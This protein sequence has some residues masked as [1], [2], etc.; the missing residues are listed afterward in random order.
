MTNS[1]ECK[2]NEMSEKY[3][4]TS[5]QY[6]ATPNIKFLD[7]LD[8]YCKVNNAE[9]I[10]LPM[11][12]RSIADE[13][14]G[15]HERLQQYKIIDSNYNL[16]SKIRISSYRILPQM[17]DPIT[18]LARF[19]QNDVSTIFASPKVRMKVIPNSNKDLPKVLMT[20]G[21]VTNPYYRDNR[22]GR[23]A[24]KDHTYAALVVETRGKIEYH[25]RQLMSLKNG[26]FFDLGMKYN[27][28]NTPVGSRPEAF[29]LGDW[30][31]GDTNKKVKEETFRMIT[32]YNPKRI[33]LHDFFNGYS[34]NHHENGNIISQIRKSGIT[35]ERELYSVARELGEFKK[36]IDGN[37]EIVIVKSNHDEW[38]NQYI[39]NGGFMK[40]SKNT[41]IGAKLLSEMV[42]GVDP[43]EY[44]LRRYSDSNVKFLS[45]DDDYKVRGW[46]LGS[47]GHLGAN[48]ARG[49]L[50]SIEAA[51][52]K[53]ITG[54]KHSPEVFRNTWVV[55][56]ST[57]LKLEYNRGF[58]SWMNTHA[59]LYE[60][61]LAQLIN[62]ING[63]HKVK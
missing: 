14:I 32:E 35:L 56:T 12:G 40:D 53:S 3:V 57:D 43:L 61:G 54:H 25:Y 38:L 27:G 49:S 30:H 18:G 24:E 17:I 42:Q 4:I 50:R 63:R 39:E 21:A 26:I 6:G 9:L 36:V 37:T 5:A 23:I 48:G 55:G 41:I 52:G 15:L 19:T 47:H 8:K 44:S 20:T 2:V 1:L 62:I 58:S 59:L 33:I 10:I 28:S 16:N 46:Q 29:I 34:I 31:V 51:H 60:N 7:S 11:Q 13:E 22:I 45:V